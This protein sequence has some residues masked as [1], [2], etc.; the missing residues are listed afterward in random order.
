MN[1]TIEITKWQEIKIDKAD[2]K[3]K[4]SKYKYASWQK[5][6]KLLYTNFPYAKVSVI[7]RTEA[8]GNILQYHGN[9][10]IG[11][12]VYVRIVVDEIKFDFTECLCILDGANNAQKLKEYEFVDKYGK[13]KKV[14]AFAMDDVNNTIQRC[15]VKAIARLGIGLNVYEN[16]YAEVDRKYEKIEESIQSSPIEKKQE[17]TNPVAKS[18]QQVIKTKDDAKAVV[19]KIDFEKS[20][21]SLLQTKDMEELKNVFTSIYNKKSSFTPEEYNELET[22]KNNKKEHFKN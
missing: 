21:E 8:D 4:E 3:E 10:N 7:S 13:T 9:E 18:T 19:E 6:W 14:K 5:A 22:I 15:T 11:Y 16:D 12:S 2:T 17:Q 1:E 20:K